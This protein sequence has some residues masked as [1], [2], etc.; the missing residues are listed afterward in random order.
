M[1]ELFGA[2][3]STIAAVLAVLVVTA[4][5]SVG[6]I[7]LRNRTMFRMGLRNLP[8]RRAQTAL[9]IA[10]LTLSTLV[11]TA[12]FVTGD[13]IQ[14]SFTKSSYDTLQRTDMDISLNGPRELSGDH[15]IAIDGEQ[16]AVD[17]SVIPVLETAFAGDSTSPASSP[18]GS[19]QPP[20]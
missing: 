8:R 3:T 10:G 19:K 11:V 12:A 20:P 15:G 9:I 18:C 6:L 13:T 1:N 4:I 14:H 17:S 7:A 2:P 5:L 16:V